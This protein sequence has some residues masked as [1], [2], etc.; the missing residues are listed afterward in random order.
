MFIMACIACPP[1]ARALSFHGL[2]NFPRILSTWSSV[3]VSGLCDPV[4]SGQ[5]CCLRQKCAQDS[6]DANPN[7]RCL[8]LSKRGANFFFLRLS[9]ASGGGVAPR[10]PALLQGPTRRQCLFFQPNWP[11]RRRLNVLS[12]EASVSCRRCHFLIGEILPQKS[13]PLNLAAAELPSRLRRFVNA[14]AHGTSTS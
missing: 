11:C 2:S 6:L 9:L 8:N 3:P 4:L 12:A 7:Q 5:S 10:Y 1:P 14:R 13:L